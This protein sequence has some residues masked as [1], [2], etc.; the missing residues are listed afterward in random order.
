MLK[1]ITILIL[2]ST[3]SY[4]AACESPK[5]QL[6]TEQLARLIALKKSKRKD[7]ERISEAH[8]E[9]IVELEGGEENATLYHVSPKK[10]NKPKQ[11]RT[12]SSVRHLNFE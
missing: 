11:H 1:N 12:Y 6:T 10:K 9:L 2:L 8:K 3:V 5:Q 7:L 4:T